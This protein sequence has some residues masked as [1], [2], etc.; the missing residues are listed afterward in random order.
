MVKTKTV[1]ATMQSSWNSHELLVGMQKGIAT[2]ENSFAVSYKGND[3]SVMA[4]SKSVFTRGKER[5]WE[6]REGGI[7]KI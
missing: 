3:R 2:L 4:E 6:G 7:T 5:S 1:L